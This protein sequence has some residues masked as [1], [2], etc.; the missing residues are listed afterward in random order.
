V[1]GS[2]HDSRISPAAESWQVWRLAVLSITQV[3]SWGVLFYSM[4]VAAPTARG[5]S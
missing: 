5:T 4:I 3:V 2:E 1:S